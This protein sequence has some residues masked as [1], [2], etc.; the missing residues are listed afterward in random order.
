MF[1]RADI[2]GDQ[3]KADIFWIHD[4]RVATCLHQNISQGRLKQHERAIHVGEHTGTPWSSNQ[5]IMTQVATV[6]LKFAIGYKAEDKAFILSADQLGDIADLG[7]G[8]F[9]YFHH[10]ST[11]F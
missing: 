2:H 11:C 6:S 9:F 3:D 1:S 8:Y 4:L 10:L 7:T 5:I